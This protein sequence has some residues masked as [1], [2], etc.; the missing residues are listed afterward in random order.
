MAPQCFDTTLAKRIAADLLEVGAIKLQP[1]QPFT[2]ASGWQSPIYCDNRMSLSYP[3]V[4]TTIKHAF[5]KLIEEQ[6]PDVRGVVGVATAGIPQGALVADTLDLPFAYVRSSSKSHGL[7]NQV[8]GHLK[9]GQ[10]VVVVEDLVSTGGSSIKAIEALR[11]GGVDVLGLISIFTYGFQDALKNLENADV[12]LTY[13]SDYETL[14]AL[15]LEKKL[16]P[17]TLLAT[18]QAWRQ[19]PESWNRG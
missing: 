18:L 16:I 13:L 6:Y 10:K 9:S 2:W 5:V 12:K 19:H 3:S 15:A 11:T 14:L 8:E 7:Q 4:R 1:D 17:E